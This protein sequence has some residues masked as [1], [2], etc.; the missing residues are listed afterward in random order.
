M[1]LT[2]NDILCG[3][4]MM[5]STFIQCGTFRTNLTN[6]AFLLVVVI[7]SQL[8][9]L[10]NLL[11]I[12]IYRF[13]FTVCI[14]RLRIGWKTKMSVIQ[15]V[16]ILTFCCLYCCIPFI[17]W[18]KED[19]DISGCNLLSLFGENS[20]N[21]YAY[22]GC[23][24]LLPLAVL[25]IFYC[26]TSSV[27]RRNIVNKNKIPVHKRCER[28]KTVLTTRTSYSFKTG[29]RRDEIEI[30]EILDSNSDKR[31]C[32]KCITASSDQS[33]SKRVVSLNHL[34]PNLRGCESKSGRQVEHVVES[35]LNENITCLKTHGRDA[36]DKSK[37]TA[38]KESGINRRANKDIQRQCL[39]LIGV[40]LMGINI[41]TWPA[42]IISV[43]EAVMPSWIFPRFVTQGTMWLIFNNSLFNPWIYTVQ[44]AEFRDALKEMFKQI[45]KAR[46]PNSK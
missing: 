33:I 13:V 37:D 41:T 24:L 20:R 6:C 38:I 36:L 28:C 43:I 17:I 30:Q 7:I 11:S 35:M 14:D 42:V 31:V 32:I 5:L 44:S 34:R 3:V 10:Y 40:I 19:L 39:I 22:F 16:V 4:A 1:C 18:A 12:C 26:V 25:N 8:S 2:L 15:I 21:V 9:M 27:V 45:C 29:D 46:H 23:G